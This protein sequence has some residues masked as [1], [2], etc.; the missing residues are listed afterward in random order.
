MPLGYWYGSPGEVRRE[1]AASYVTGANPRETET[2]FPS[3]P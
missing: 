3:P 1:Q 2:G